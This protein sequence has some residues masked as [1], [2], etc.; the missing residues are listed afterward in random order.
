L[1]AEERKLSKSDPAFAKIPVV[2]SDTGA[3]L[4][5]VEESVEFQK[6]RSAE[7]AKELKKVGKKKFDSNG[8]SE[9][10]I[11]LLP[12]RREPTKT[13]NIISANPRP[14]K[15]LCEEGLEVALHP[16]PADDMDVEELYTISE[17]DFDEGDYD[18]EAFAFEEQPMG[19]Q[20]QRLPAR[21]R[22]PPSF[23][24]IARG[25]QPPPSARSLNLHRFHTRQPLPSSRTLAHPSSHMVSQPVAGPSRL[26]PRPQGY[27]RDS[28]RSLVDLARLRH[29]E[30]NDLEWES[31]M[32]R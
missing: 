12:S 32:N 6:E 10:E 29:E 9:H 19:F 15:C 31:T 5:R 24:D 21:S 30:F 27:Y 1:Y 25:G 4:Q 22:A 8:H 18:G 11:K 17:K 13:I 26:G 28:G 20:A 3:I 16:N 23:H 7:Q 14:K 2:I